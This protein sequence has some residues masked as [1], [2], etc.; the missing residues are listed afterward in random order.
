MP[1]LVK[2]GAVMAVL[3]APVS[4]FPSPEADI[5][6]LKASLSALKDQYERRIQDLEARL[7]RAERQAAGAATV[8]PAVS[9]RPVPNPATVST[10]SVYAPTRYVISTYTPG[11][12]CPVHT[13]ESPSLR[14]AY[15]SIPPNC[16]P[17]SVL[18]RK[19]SVVPGIASPFR[20][21]EAF[22]IEEIIDP[23]DTRPILCDFIEMAQPMLKTQ[24]GPASGPSYWP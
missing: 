15:P 9:A 22:D 2:R 7:A 5:A 14:N 10:S 11:V 20:T 21:A 16:A 12:T 6:E 13:T 4:A 23:R 1:C 8:A 3:L 19:V 24:L 17:S 18:P